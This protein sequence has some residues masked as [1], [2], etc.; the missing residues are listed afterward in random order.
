MN[1]INE[2]NTTNLRI[3]VSLVLAVIY[4]LVILAGA[5]LGKQMPMEALNTAGLFIFGMM[6]VDAAQFIG[7][8]FSDYNYAAA[9]N[10][11]PQVSVAAPSTV[12]VSPVAPPVTPV[13]PPVTP[14]VPSTMA[15]SMHPTSERGD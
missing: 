13:A 4:V 7:K 9:K 11:Q 15:I 6:G 14:G 12:A 8:R 3:I 10:A 2:V 5:V 1:W